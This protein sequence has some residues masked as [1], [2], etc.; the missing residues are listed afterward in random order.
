MK[1]KLIKRLPIIST[2]VS[3]ALENNGKYDRYDVQG[4]ISPFFT[5]TADLDEKVLAYF[6]KKFPNQTFG[7]EPELQRT[8]PNNSSAL[9]VESV[10]DK[11]PVNRKTRSILKKNPIKSWVHEDLR[12][13]FKDKW[14][15]LRQ[16]W[17]QLLEFYTNPQKVV[18]DSNKYQLL[19]GVKASKQGV[20]KHLYRSLKDALKSFFRRDLYIVGVAKIFAIRAEKAQE[21]LALAYLASDLNN[22]ASKNA[23]SGVLSTPFKIELANCIGNPEPIYCYYCYVAV[24]LEFI[25][26]A[27]KLKTYSLPGAMPTTIFGKAPYEDLMGET[28]NIELEDLDPVITGIVNNP[29]RKKEVKNER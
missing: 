2:N 5:T 29:K 27:M 17:G 10:L 20:R 9:K 6:Q 19:E 23:I 13:G 28:Y 11:I 24:K 25:D 12:W 14:T 4:S 1:T 3:Y 7:I 15:F 26:F 16:Q 8:L 18:D 21:A 22:L